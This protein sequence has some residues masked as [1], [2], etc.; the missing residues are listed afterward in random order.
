MSLNSVNLLDDDEMPDVS[1]VTPKEPSPPPAPKV[2]CPML[3]SECVGPGVLVN[4]ELQ[5]CKMWITLTNTLPDGSTNQRADCGFAFQAMWQFEALQV[6]AQNLAIAQQAQANANALVAES[7]AAG[8]S[9]PGEIPPPPAE[10]Q[11]T[12]VPDVPADNDPKPT[13]Q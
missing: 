5:T 9:L 10:N 1:D 6:Q 2:M 7:T 13:L 8:G 11:P 4:G 12:D 3:K